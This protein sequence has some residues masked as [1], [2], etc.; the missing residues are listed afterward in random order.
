MPNTDRLI[1]EIKDLLKMSKI[2]QI[3]L[4]AVILCMSQMSKM[5]TYTHILNTVYIK[6]CRRCR[7]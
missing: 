6:A 3:H 5:G 1:H 7:R 2:D 4:R